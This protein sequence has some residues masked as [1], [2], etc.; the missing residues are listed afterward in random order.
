MA[1]YD[2]NIQNRLTCV[3]CRLPY[4]RNHESES[5]LSPRA[6]S[7]KAAVGS[8]PPTQDKQKTEKSKALFFTIYCKKQSSTFFCFL[9]AAFEAGGNRPQP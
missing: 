4:L 6:F 5:K 3:G 9:L 8:R 7:A 1:E 2:K